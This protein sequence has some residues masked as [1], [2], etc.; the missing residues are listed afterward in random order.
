MKGTFKEHKATIIYGSM[1]GSVE[2]ALNK[3]V[4]VLR[5]KGFNVKA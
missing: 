5:A 2:R 4:K 1:Y 3:T